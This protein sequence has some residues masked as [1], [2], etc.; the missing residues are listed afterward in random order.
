MDILAQRAVELV[1]TG[2]ALLLLSD[3]G[4]SPSAIP[5]PMALAT[6]A[7][8]QALTTAGVRAEAGLAVE[9]GD[10]REI[11]H[12]AVLLGMGA[13]AVCP[14]LALETAR[15][16]DPG[17]ARKTCSTLS[18]WAW[19]RLCRRWASALW[20]AIAALTFLTLSGFQKQ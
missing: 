14:W 19:P 16:L 15:D 9:A 6:G 7:V 18:N 2:A 20:T 8:H 10:C 5:I 13:G 1:G 3:R 4:A 17:K 11:H 12:V